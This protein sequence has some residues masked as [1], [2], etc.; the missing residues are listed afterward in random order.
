MLHKG[1]WFEEMIN[2]RNKSVVCAMKWSADGERICIA[3]RDG[4][5]IVGSVDG[6]RLWGKE[7]GMPLEMLEWSPNSQNIHFAYALRRVQNGW[8]LEDRKYYF[9]WLNETLEKNGGKSFAGYIRAIREDAIN[10]LPAEAAAAVSWLLGEIA[11]VDLSKLPTAKGPAVAWTVESAMKL[12]EPELE[13]RDF[14]N[15]EKMF[16]AGRCVAC[17]RFGGSGGYSGPDLGSVGNRYSIRDILVAICDPSQSISEQYQASTVTLK[18][19]GLVYGR[20]IYKN[21]DEIAIAPNPFNFGDITKTPMD[22]V[23]GVELSQLSMMPLRW[24]TRTRCRISTGFVLRPS[25]YAISAT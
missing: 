3:Y 18:D 17:H 15:G 25:I 20:I 16:A 21:D 24:L 19:G 6:N 9:G 8:T 2:N 13:G 23:K 14:K 10:H 1:T 22:K 12:F 7:L 4:A 11:A 5:V